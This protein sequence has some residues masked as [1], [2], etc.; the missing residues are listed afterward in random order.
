MI[1]VSCELIIGQARFTSLWLSAHTMCSCF[2]RPTS[3]SFGAWQVSTP[4]LGNEALSDEAKIMGLS[5]S[6]SLPGQRKT[7]KNRRNQTRRELYSM[8]HAH[9]SNIGSTQ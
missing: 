4:R 2:E 5:L 7:R 8:H 6:L 9:L 3:V 1:A